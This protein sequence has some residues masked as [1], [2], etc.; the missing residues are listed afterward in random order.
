MID[1]VA[2]QTLLLVGA[3]FL[4]S[5]TLLPSFPED[6]GSQ[7]QGGGSIAAHDL[8]G[9]QLDREEGLMAPTA[10][11]VISIVQPEAPARLSEGIKSANKILHSATDSLSYQSKA[12]K[13]NT[14]SSGSV[15]EGNAASHSEPQTGSDAAP[16]L[17]KVRSH[18]EREGPVTHIGEGERHLTGP[19][20]EETGAD[21]QVPALKEKNPG[22][23]SGSERVPR[24]RRMSGGEQPSGAFS[25][26]SEIGLEAS[27]TPALETTLGPKFA[28]YPPSPSMVPVALEAKGQGEEL[29][30]SEEAGPRGTLIQN[31]VEGIGEPSGGETSEGEIS[32]A[33][34]PPTRVPGFPSQTWHEDAQVTVAMETGPHLDGT[35]APGHPEWRQT[36]V[37]GKVIR[38]PSSQALDM[39]SPL[40]PN[41][42]PEWSTMGE[43]PPQP[44]APTPAEQPWDSYTLGTGGAPHQDGVEEQG[45]TPSPDAPKTASQPLLTA[46]RGSDEPISED[47]AL[48]PDREGTLSPDHLPLL[49]EPLDDVMPE[50]TG[51]AP[52]GGSLPQPSN[53]MGPEAE[54]V[55][56]VTVDEDGPPS[57]D[58]L[59]D[60]PSL[61]WQM[62]GS[63]IPD[64]VGSSVLPSF[65]APPSGPLLRTADPEERSMTDTATEDRPISVETPPPSATGQ[66]LLA[67]VARVTGLSL[68]KPKSGLEELEYEEEHDEDEEDEDTDDYEEEEEHETEAPVLAATPPAYSHVPRPPLWVQRNHGLVRSWVEKIRDEAG[69][70]SGM[71]AP[72]GIGIA[73][74]LLILGVLYSIRA[75]HRKRRNTIK[76]QRRKR[77]MTSRQDQ[78]MLLADS[79]E[80]EL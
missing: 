22:L 79:S 30:A 54:L 15:E 65:T 27:V 66:T 48:E 11:V 63:E 80:D 59:P 46:A 24:R 61:A 9:G 69:Y 13:A 3:G 55:E 37:L 75:A 74:A 64:A 31:P 72:V 45:S 70:V 42:A 77:E 44:E 50:A 12:V 26:H 34:T 52:P 57:E 8:A 39:L 73:G 28:L 67:T 56:M 7:K 60:S 76:Q 47:L 78:A 16:F 58:L 4:V 2:V 19:I 1:C 51:A 20:P 68:S 17:V 41:P 18:P 49:F 6:H 40:T 38:T 53:G 25:A 14:W 33:K 29:R 5:A 21:L 36:A 23:E 62:S 32:I 43:T 71:L 35:P 10:A